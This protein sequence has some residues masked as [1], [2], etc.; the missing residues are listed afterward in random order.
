MQQAGLTFETA[1]TNWERFFTGA[2]RI[3]LCELNRTEEQIIST[4]LRFA[5]G[6]IPENSPFFEFNGRQN[7][8]ETR[9]TYAEAANIEERFYHHAQTRLCEK[10]AI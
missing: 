3:I 8:V 6:E 5:P 2:I 10:Y 7:M 1:S 9:I 4:H